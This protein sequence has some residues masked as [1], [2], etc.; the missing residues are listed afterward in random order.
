MYT[1]EELQETIEYLEKKVD[2]YEDILDALLSLMVDDDVFSENT[3]CKLWDIY[4]DLS[5]DL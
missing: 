4:N 5:K 1:E 2:R 3:K